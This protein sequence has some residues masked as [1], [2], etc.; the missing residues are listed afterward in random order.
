MSVSGRTAGK[1]A[2]AAETSRHARACSTTPGS[3]ASAVS[4]SA[5]RRNEVPAAGNTTDW[6]SR[7]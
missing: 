7:C 2:G 5:H 6:P 1:I 4:S 3:S